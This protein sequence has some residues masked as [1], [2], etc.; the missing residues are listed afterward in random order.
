MK[1]LEVVKCSI[2]ASLLAGGCFGLFAANKP[3][4]VVEPSLIVPEWSGATP[5]VWTMDY[6]SALANAQAEGKWTL[7]LYSGMWWCPHCQPLE[8]HVLTQPAFSNYVA[9][10]GYYTTVLDN[11]YRDGYSNWC[12]LYETNYVENVA[13]LTMEEALQEIDKRY[14]VQESYALPG[15]TEYN[16]SNWN[17]T[18]TITYHKVG[19]PTII[20]IRPDGRPAG[21]FGFSKSQPAETA[22]TY[23][24]NLIE[25]VKR[26]D[27]WDEIDDYWQTTQTVLPIPANVG[28]VV[29]H[30]EHVLSTRD[31][32]DWY[33]IEIADDT[34]AHWTFLFDQV[35]G[36]P[37]AVLSAG[38]YEAAS[39]SEDP[40][41]APLAAFEVDFA[42]T[43][44][45]A[46]DFPSAGTYYL[47]V[48]ATKLAEVVGYRLSY[49]C[50]AGRQIEFGSSATLLATGSEYAMPTLRDMDGDDLLD[51]V[52]GV[53]E[54]LASEKGVLT[55]YVGRVRIY[56]NTGTAEEPRFG[57][58]SY[59]M[60]NGE[61]LED[62]LEKNSGCQGLKVEF[63][64]FDG[65]GFDDLFVGHH[66][67]ELDVYW[68][69]ADQN[70]FSGTAR[71]R[72]RPDAM[73]GYRTVPCAHD[74]D[75]DG[76]VELY[77]GRIDGTFA[78]FTCDAERNVADSGV[79]EDGTGVALT[80]AGSR[81]AP[82][83][84][85]MDGDG[86][87]DLVSGD[88]NGNILF[89]PATGVGKWSAKP[90]TLVV[91]KTGSRSRIAVADINGD[92]TVDVAVGYADGTVVMMTGSNRPEISCEPLEEGYVPGIAVEPIDVVVDPPMAA[93]SITATGLPS[94]LSLKM[95]K[96]SGAYR[97]EGTPTSPGTNNVVLKLAYTAG[98]MRKESELTVPIKVL[99][100]PVVAVEVESLDG[101]T[102]RVTGAGSYLAGK[103]ITLAAS[104]DTKS[105]SVFAGWYVG[106][107]PLE[108]GG[109]DYRTQRIQLEVPPDPETRL[110]AVFSTQAEDAS[111][112]V[113]LPDQMLRAGEEMD[114]VQVQVASLSFPTVSAKGLPVGVK[115]DAKTLTLSGTPTKPGEYVVTFTAKNVS[116][117]TAERTTRITV[118]N[119][120]SSEIGPL[121]ESYAFTAGIACTNYFDVAG[122]TVSGLP[123]GLKMDKET[124]M[125]YGTPSTPGTWLVTFTKKVGKAS[126][127]ATTWFYV[128][129]AGDALDGSDGIPVVATALFDGEEAGVTNG[130]WHVDLTQGVAW[131][132][133]IGSVPTVVQSPVS[134]SVKGLPAGL[135][136]DSKTG[137]IS[138][139]PTKA[140]AVDART[141]TV[142]PTLVTV[143]ASN[144]SKWKGSLELEMVVAARPAWAVGTYDGVSALDGTNGLFTATVAESGT[145]SGK[146]TI[147]SKSY[148]FKAA[149]LAGEIEDGGFF[150][151]AV[152]SISKTRVVTNRLVLSSSVYESA[153]A[154]GIDEDTLVGRMASEDDVLDGF[155]VT[156]CYQN[157]WLRKDVSTFRLPVF[158]SGAQ[159]SLPVVR[160]NLQLRFGQRGKVTVAGK[161]DGKSVSGSCQ[162]LATDFGIPSCFC[163][164]SFYYNGLI[165]VS[166]PRQD[167]FSVVTF[168]GSSGAVKITGKD[169]DYD[170][171]LMSDDQIAD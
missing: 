156:N 56:R 89:F 12:W 57:G 82:A 71:M 164:T 62:V 13:H 92:G 113:Y 28:D 147:G 159:K 114:G 171:E 109:V 169:E 161:I 17:G 108:F 8:K 160:G 67:G 101:G 41:A 60:V 102:G 132:C 64:D 18:A 130:A 157:L 59:L 19:Y 31:S 166:L 148:S 85:D 10:C 40:K 97:I 86:L 124:G 16:I 32:A 105:K 75:E 126:E 6:A 135:K 144:A 52:V 139:A 99:P 26:H 158:A 68:G 61:V 95:D 129:G 25:Q 78:V 77:V 150:V 140:S 116:K 7:M 44:S 36:L 137:V 2:V 22:I 133:A 122:C 79:L 96:A 165:P 50:G 163:D 15:A 48:G 9:E 91:G 55:G 73:T 37:T 47:K 154:T 65:D 94:G 3:G 123:A 29:V 119:F 149:S 145:V 120:A 151:D 153:E 125:V 30:G 81:S 74:F 4:Y 117:A 11:P 38:I 35:E 83:F 42:A 33:K 63:G 51:L 90:V 152:A 54:P 142:K 127:K 87:L 69:T 70:V 103:K 136:F 45:I 106:E 88:T 128:A 121:E 76:R 39:I 5:G 20:V 46:V 21:R 24:T 49:L 146:Y 155:M 100:L 34:P 58:Y 80:A 168:M 111:I 1:K 84:A 134:F 66:W 162:L 107:H 118:L 170:L 115:F 104:P 43:P 131:R 53:K 14:L 98:G 138:G 27:D 143:T 93:P 110:T 167:Y 141:G 72:E 23:V 112:A